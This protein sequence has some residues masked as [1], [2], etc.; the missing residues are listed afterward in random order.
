MLNMINKKHIIA[1]VAIIATLL[2]LLLS[3]AYISEYIEH[4]CTGSDCA[5]CA[6]LE[7]CGNTLKTIGAAIIVALSVL[8]ISAFLK[9]V[10]GDIVNICT[11]NS[12]IS[13]RVRMNN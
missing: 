4:D 12:L 1:W 8:F 3:T 9:K 7:Q 11:C 10:T 13:Q 6:V 5:V 2:V